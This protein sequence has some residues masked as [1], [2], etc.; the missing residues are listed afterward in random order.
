MLYNVAVSRFKADSRL[1][2]SKLAQ[3]FSELLI[4]ENFAEV[5]RW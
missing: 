5:P 4:T 3:D 2:I 1:V